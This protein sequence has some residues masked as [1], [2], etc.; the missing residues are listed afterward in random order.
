MI[1]RQPKAPDPEPR[2]PFVSD[3]LHFI[4]MTALVWLR[5]S[6][7]FVFLRSKA[8]FFAFSF[9]FILMEIIAWHYDFIWRYVRALCI[10]GTT[11]VILYWLHLLR[12]WCSELLRSAGHDNYAGTP[13]TLRLLKWAGVKSFKNLETAVYWGVEPVIVLVAAVAFRV[14]FSESYLSL[15]L[16]VTAAAM[17]AKEW[18][19][20]WFEVRREKRKGQMVDEI[21]LEAQRRADLAARSSEASKNTRKAAQNRPRA[22]TG[23][24]GDDK[25]RRHAEVLQLPDAYDLQI[26]EQHFRD[27]IKGTH[28]DRNDDSAESTRETSALND[29]RDYFRKKFGG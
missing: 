26:V 11:T 25:E 27:L 14:L 8:V 4:A 21:V 12:S 2:I 20:H 28:P 18:L 29:A 7:G 16:F 9:S 22:R 19:N 15:W 10:F 17:C 23:S 6:F 13:H 5:S 24:T 3:L 1:D